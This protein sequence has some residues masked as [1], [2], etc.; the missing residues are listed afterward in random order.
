MLYYYVCIPYFYIYMIYTCICM[1]YYYIYTIFV[2]I[3]NIC[4]K[5]YLSKY[6][7]KY[8]M[9]TIMFQV[10]LDFSVKLKLTSVCQILVSLLEQ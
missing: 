8:T 1:L 3:R 9:I 10:M 2:F 6:N 5:Y 7:I 4:M